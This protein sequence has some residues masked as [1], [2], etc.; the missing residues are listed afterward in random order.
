MVVVFIIKVLVICIFYSLK[1]C[2]VGFTFQSELLVHVSGLRVTYIHVLS[3][4]QTN[5]QTNKQT[6]P[7]FEYMFLGLVLHI[8]MFT[9]FIFF[10]VRVTYIH[11]C[12]QKIKI[13]I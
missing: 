6:K 11:A 9:L 4:K 10:L 8:F 3:Q 13:I 7:Q 12:P 2:G 1:K 5:K